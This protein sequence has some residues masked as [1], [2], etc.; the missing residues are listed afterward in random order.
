MLR[1]A[2]HI[3]GYTVKASDGDMGKVKDVL[4]DDRQWTIRYIVVDTGHWLPGRQV[5]ISPASVGKADWNSKELGVALDRKRIEESPSIDQDM[6]VSR[7]KELELVKYYGWIPYWQTG[8]IPM[9]VAMMTPI[10][11]AEETT[12]DEVKKGDPHLR[13]IHEVVGY[14]IHATDGMIG[15]VDDFIVQTDGWVIRYIVADTRNWIPGRKVLVSPTWAHKIDWDERAV[16]IDMEREIIRH[17]AVYDHSSPIN[18]EYEVH[19]YDYYGR[20]KYWK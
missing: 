7:Q 2:K 11:P 4:F 13:S 1:S 16:Y 9:G 8:Q 5:L 10:M 19:L 20:P 17:S 15:H 3:L 6:P 14:H 12:P 18:R